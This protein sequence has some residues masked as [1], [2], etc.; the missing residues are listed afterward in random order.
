MNNIKSIFDLLYHQSF[1]SDPGKE[2]ND[3]DLVMIDADTMGLVSSFLEAKG[4]LSISKIEMLKNCIENLE[5]II[6]NLNKSEKKYFIEL[7]DLASKVFE[8]I[9]NNNY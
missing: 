4:K 5:V 6:P 7:K 3:V 2:I 8:Q 9:E 1:P